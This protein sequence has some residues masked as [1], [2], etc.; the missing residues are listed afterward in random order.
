MALSPTDPAVQQYATAVAKTRSMAATPQPTATP[1]AP[2]TGGF[3]N[4]DTSSASMSGAPVAQ[5]YTPS[6]PPAG[7]SSGGTPTTNTGSSGG[8]WTMPGITDPTYATIGAGFQ[9]RADTLKS[10]A[11]YQKQ[12]LAALNSSNRASLQNE[13]V[14]A[15]QGITNDAE[16]RGIL[17]SGELERNLAE[18]MAKE[19]ERLSNMDLNLA[20]QT[21]QIDTGLADQLSGLR[22]DFNTQ[23]QRAYQ[24]Q[25]AEQALQK[26]K[27][28][29]QAKLYTNSAGKSNANGMGLATDPSGNPM[30]GLFSDG[31][32]YYYVDNGIINWLSPDQLNNYL[33]QGLR[34]SM[35]SG[36]NVDDFRKA[37]NVRL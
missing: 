37:G 35:L 1:Q 23:Q 8:E 25:A 19:N 24:Q 28:D 21:G 20:A 10:N 18:Q 26:A 11:E 17:R 13:G 34:P 7:T 32:A 15:R 9:Q 36:Q 29:A 27:E 31:L 4:G 33:A 5:P 6:L 14:F 3:G 16:G 12:M 22:M 30:T 2:A